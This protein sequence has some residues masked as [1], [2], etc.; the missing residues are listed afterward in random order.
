MEFGALT[1]RTPRAREEL[2]TG[3]LAVPGSF[4]TAAVRMLPAG[5]NP[6]DWVVQR[7]SSNVSDTTP[8]AVAYVDASLLN[9]RLWVDAPAPGDVMC[10]LGMTGRKKKLSDILGTARVPV[11]ERHLVPVVRTEPG[12]AVVWL[13]GI[14]LDERFKCTER[15][16]R[17]VKLTNRP[18]TGA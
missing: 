3:W 16:T 13:P 12:G 6:L 8:A 15:S 7:G 14:R 2:A 5:V 1:L 17:L 18:V 4:A 11:A 10:P 9:G